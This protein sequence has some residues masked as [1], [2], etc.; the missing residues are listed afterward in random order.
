MGLINTILGTPLGFVIHYAYMLLGSFG[1]AVLVFAVAVK[2]ILMPVMALAHRNSIRLLQLQPKLHRLKIR[3][4]GDRH[5]LSE[6]QYELFKQEKYSPLVGILPL[7][8]QLFLVI[9]MLQVMYHPLQHVF[10][11]DSAVID[12]LVYTAEGITGVTAGF[13]AQLVNMDVF[14]N[15]AYFALF[16]SAL[17][18]N[19]A[20]LLQVRGAELEFLGL[21][22]AMIPSFAN[23]SI[24]L[25]IIPLSGIVALAF[26]LVQNAIS[27]G[28]L[29]QSRNTNIGLTVF[30]VCISLYFAWALPV[31]VGIYWTVGNIAAIGVVFTL[32]AI[33]PPRKLAKDALEFLEGTRKTKEELLDEKVSNKELKTREKAYVRL[34]SK[35][36]KQIVFYALTGGQYRY[37]KTILDYLADHSS[38][39]IHYLTNDPND[40]VFS[41]RLPNIV[42]YYVSQ[43]RSITLFLKLDA[44]ILVT[45]VPDLQSFHM[46]RSI[47]RDDIEYIHVIHGPSSTIAAMREQTFD[48]FDTIF[49]V[50]PHNVREIRCREAYAGLKKKTLVK[51]GYGQYDQLADLYA[52]S[53]S[54]AANPRPKLTI[55]PSWQPQNILESCAEEIVNALL[56]HGYEIIIRPH[57]QFVRLYPE[58]IKELNNRYE[59]Q[60]ANGELIIEL[61]FSD[62]S[63]IFSSDLLISDWSGVA[64]EFSYCTSKPCV[65]VNTPMKVLNPNYKDY[66]VQPLDIELRNEI[67]RAVDLNDVRNIHMV[68]SDLLCNSITYAGRIR[69]ALDKLVYNPGRSGEAGGKYLIKR[70]ENMNER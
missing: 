68:V 18:G 36:K 14:Q 9:G 38:L 25:I 40:A 54:N 19:E 3:H 55:A 42:P 11:L 49:C 1:L 5:G 47:I 35:A 21:N 69:E 58:R 66:P 61:D 34:F 39:T 27:P 7:V 50:G 48:H 30:T 22:L 17:Y 13:A 4:S 32:N 16:D 20:A 51:I 10:R 12:T 65:F 28:A 56:G 15:P 26:C 46:K 43:K 33:Y 52:K 37:Y 67:G 63:S 23:P 57:T 2:I 24:E 53:R 45:T 44:D 31:G 70:I 6:A 60:V 62:N 59:K 41:R 8:I 29:S 64:Y